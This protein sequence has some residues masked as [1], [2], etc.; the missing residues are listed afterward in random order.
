M[1]IIGSAVLFLVLYSCM[2]FARIAVFFLPQ[3][4][5]S[6]KKRILFLSPFFPENAGYIYRAAKWAE[7]LESKGFDVEI[8]QT[9]EKDQFY[10]YLQ[11]NDVRFFLITLFKRTWQVLTSYKYDIVIVRRELLLYNDY[12]NLFLEKALLKIHPDAILDFD[13]D[14]GAAK[15]EP[16]KVESTFG[17]LMLEDGTKFRN[18]LKL[19]RK[20]IVG[21]GYLKQLAMS[22]NIEIEDRDVCIIPTC[23]DYEKFPQKKYE[24]R[25]DSK[26]PVVLGWIGSNG[27]LPL[28][29]AIIPQLNQLNKEIP[30]KMIVISGKEFAPDADFEIEN[31]MWSYETQID[32][33]LD[34]DIGLMPLNDTVRERG[35]CGFKLIQ[36]MG[37]GIVSAAGAI[38]VNKEIV[39]DNKNGFLVQTPE[40]WTETLRNAINLIDKFP[41]I[42]EAAHHQ[43]LTKYSFIS[44]TKRYIE[45][46]ESIDPE[47]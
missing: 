21:S 23:V 45:F 27:N 15:L 17:K 22:I 24:L 31:R 37:L 46:I 42:G 3:R 13:D 18:S 25:N 12:G 14:I 1:N 41:E 39:E 2:F 8:K 16:R 6:E 34:I 28:L 43:I 38:S 19:Y 33:M 29:E 10:R 26:I 47:T 4:T 36:Y 5:G 11:K 30:L 9:L 44:N 35:K 40:D 20:F 32:D 7:I